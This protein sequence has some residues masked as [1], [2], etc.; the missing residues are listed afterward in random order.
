MKDKLTYFK[1]A[2][3]QTLLPITEQKVS[4]R[5]SIEP[6][7]EFTKSSNALLGSIS[8]AQSELIGLF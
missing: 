8:R 3:T 5:V 2:I 1:I 4:N 7:I 6:K